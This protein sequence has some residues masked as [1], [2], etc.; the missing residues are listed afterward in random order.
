MRLLF[1]L[2]LLVTFSSLRAQDSFN[3]TTQYEDDLVLIQVA[4]QQCNDPANDFTFTYHFIRLKNKSNKKVEVSFAKLAAKGADLDSD[5]DVEVTL[6]PGQIMAANCDT[7]VPM[8]KLAIDS[9]EHTR[10]D[11]VLSDIE[12]EEL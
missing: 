10:V 7:D 4:R 2:L 9:E 12:V 11:N 3:W 1:L 6:A 8:L 5:T